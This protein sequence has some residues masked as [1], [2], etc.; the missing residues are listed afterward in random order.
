MKPKLGKKTAKILTDGKEVAV[1]LS[2]FEDFSRLETFV[3][4]DLKGRKAGA[5][6]LQGAKSEY[7]FVFGFTTPGIHDTLRLDQIA[8]TI[9]NLEAALKELLPGERMTV[10]LSS[11]RDDSDRQQELDDLISRTDSPELQLLLM[12][13]KV[14]ASELKK[15]GLRKPKSLDIYVT[16]TVQADQQTDADSDWIEKTLAQGLTFFSSM[17]QSFKGDRELNEVQQLEAMLTKVFKEGYL[18]W[19]HLLNIK[20]GLELKPMSA[21]TI[22]DKL[23]SRFS[24]AIPPKVP[25]RLFLNEKGLAEEILSDLHPTTLLVAGTGGNSAV[26]KADR[27]WVKVNHK[28]V[29]AVTF[30]DKPAGFLNGRAQLRY[31]W[32]VLC[33]PQNFDAEVI[34]QISPA[35]PHLVK[36]NVQRILKQSNVAAQGAVEGNSIDVAAMVRTK[37]SVQA[38][39]KLF[40]GAIPVYVGMV[41]LVHRDTLSQLDAACSVFSECFQLPA[42]VVRESEITWQYWLQSLSVSWERLLSKPFGRQLTYL[43]NEAPGLIPLTL[44]RSVSKHGFELIADEGGSPIHLDIIREHRNMAVFGTTRSGKSVL[45]SGILTEALAEGLPIV[46][47]DY[48]KPDGTSTFSDYAKFLKG[49]AAYFDVGKESNNLMEMPDLSG[50]DPEQQQER[51]DDYKAFLESAVVQMVLPTVQSDLLLE[52]TV[53][54]LVGRALMNFFANESIQDRYQAANRAG[55]GTSQWQETPTLRD[56]IPFCLPDAL[57]I[58]TDSAPLIRNAQSQIMLQL[59]YWLNSRVGRAIARPSSFPTDA[60]LLVFALR[61]LSN[62]NEA[63]IL[64]LS[65]YSAAL[66]RALQAPKSIFFI[67][68]SP[69]LF[70][71]ATIARL[72][73]RLCANGAKA[74]IR[75]VLSAQDPDTIMNSVAGQQIFQNMNTRLIGRIQAMATESFCRLLFYE[76][77]I[78]SR[79]SSEAF[80]PKRSELYSNWLLDIDGNYIFCRYYPSALQLA[81]VA[82]NP[83]EQEARNRIMRL[84]PGDHLRG[85]AEFAKQY[86]AAIRGGVSM[87]SIGVDE[88]MPVGLSFPMPMGEEGVLFVEPSGALRCQS[89]HADNHP[90]INT[91]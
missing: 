72:I 37:R 41:I 75:V 83:D 77:E 73:G 3:D 45:V 52:Q 12:S 34:C 36:T 78:I 7:C 13:G 33:R 91:P 20:M 42:R 90:L 2:A 25:Q 38:Q 62:E 79:N 54:S 6:M 27:Q 58:G 35:N 5:A 66:R 40:E 10:H 4:F 21:Q 22:W 60:Q 1:T 43:T 69:I 28:Y 26:P 81:A 15:S 49:R 24:S 84:F 87:D 74:G 32:E 82:N 70:A 88:S 61:N 86:F 18:R 48:P 80:Y 65:A 23:W 63:A 9:H 57:E 67:D 16:V 39:E 64:S 14:R 47:L 50:L 68:E 17:W 59:N 71:F 19:E 29:G 89:N 51:F 55:F 53:R 44:T 11:F 30:V 76:R 85:M 8:P 31:L 56:F 46:A